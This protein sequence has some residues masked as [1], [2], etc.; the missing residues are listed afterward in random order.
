MAKKPRILCIDDQVTN[1]HIR[2]AMLEQFGCETISATD[3]QSAMR[4]VEATPLDLIVIDYHL[5][6][7]ETGDT[8]ARDVRVMHAEIRL[9]MLTGDTH[10][11]KH[12]SACVDAVLVKGLSDPGALLDLIAKL[13]PAAELRPRR[14]MLFPKPPGSS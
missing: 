1:L 10:L 5:A 11:P 14:P 13:V 7:G 6:N 12:V 4:I 8:I 9:I 2:T 3:Y